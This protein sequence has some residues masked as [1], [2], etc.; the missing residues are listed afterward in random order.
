[1]KILVLNGSPRKQGTVSQL[2]KGVTDNLGKNHSVEW[3]NVYD[4]TMRPCTGCM[5]CRED[6]GCILPGDDAHH[7]GEK[8]NRADGLVIG[9]PTH[10]GN[11]SAQLKLLFDRNVPVFMG[12]KPGGMPTPRQKGKPAVIVTA[13]TTPWPFNFILPES[14]GAIRAVREVLHYGGYKLVGTITK[15]GTRTSKTISSSLTEKATRLGKK[16]SMR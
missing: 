5:T 10:W 13:C 1:M 3:V 4:L 2:L 15:P 14:R 8:I 6:H 7:V 11:M 12:E 9:T 16:L